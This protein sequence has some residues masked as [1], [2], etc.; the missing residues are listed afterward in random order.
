MI[1]QTTQSGTDDRMGPVRVVLL[2]GVLQSIFFPVGFLSVSNLLSW[3]A[4]LVV[5]TF[6]NR[7]LLGV[8][9]IQLRLFCIT[10]AILGIANF[11]SIAFNILLAPMFPIVF[12]MSLIALATHGQY[13]TAWVTSF[14]EL[15]TM[16]SEMTDAFRW[17]SSRALA[18]GDSF[19]WIGVM[20][21]AGVFLNTCMHLSIR[22]RSK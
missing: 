12:V 14:L 1:V 15:T 3:S 6:L 9:Q 10:W 20:I 19:Q 2:G 22:K 5:A 8:V 11:A 21:G 16:M 13:G 18:L 4:Y 7:S 17:L